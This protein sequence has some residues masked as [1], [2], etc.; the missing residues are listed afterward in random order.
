MFVAI[1]LII[2]GIVLFDA[3]SRL[4]IVEKR[5][6]LLESDDHARTPF[7]N[8]VTAP[9]PVEQAADPEPPVTIRPA[10][11]VETAAIPAALQP[12]AERDAPSF[13]R[14]DIDSVD[15]VQTRG[16]GFE[17][18]FGRRLPIWAGGV[19]L[20]VAGV[21]LVK[22]SIDA[23]L[24]SPLVRVVFG[25]LFGSA[26]IGGADVA[27]RQESRVRDPRV[28]QSLAGAGLATLY[29]SILAAH[30]LYDLIGPM[31][32]FVGLAGVTALAMALSIRFGAPSA[33]LGLVG[34]LAA[35]ALVNAGQPNVP[36]LSCYLALA[37]GG[38]CTLSRTQRWLWLGIG[39]LIGGAGW[40]VAMLVLGALD[41]GASISVALLLIAL[42]VAF[43]L[44]AF[45]GPRANSLRLAAAVIAAAQ[46]AALVATGGF[47]L[48]N[49]G[50][51]GLLSIAL[52]W[53]GSRAPALRPSGA[54]GLG[55]ALF[56]AGAWPIPNGTAFT[57][58]AL[59]MAAIYGGAALWRLW[60]PDGSLIEAGQVA[61]IALGGVAVSLVHFYRDGVSERFALL[62]LV[63]AALP[64]LAMTLGWRSERDEDARF[65]LLATAAAL[66]LTLSGGLAFPAWSLPITVA[67][68]GAGLLFLS[69]RADDR[70]VEW[71]GWAFAGS[72]LVILLASQYGRPESTRLF[73]EVA[74]APAAQALLRWSAIALV[75]ALFAWRARF[76]EG[77]TGA[78]GVAVLLGYGALAQV[79][80]AIWLPLVP[81][82]ALPLLAEGARLRQVRLT[83]ALGTA[84]FVSL[85]WAVW[86]LGAWAV[87]ALTSLLGQP[88]L[89]SHLPS[90][91]DALRRLALPALMLAL[92][93]WRMRVL[94]PSLQVPAV[95]TTAILGGV[96]AHI[97]YKQL[98]HLSDMP[99]VVRFAFVERTLWQALLL[100]AAGAVWHLGKAPRIALGLAV[101]A[102]VHV[103]LYT[104]LLHDPLWY[105]QEV[106]HLPIVNLLIPAFAMPYVALA[107]I[108]RLAPDWADRMRRPADMLRMATIILFAYASLRQ[109]FAG[110]VL[111]V[112]P[113]G[114]AEDIVRSVLA[115]ALAIGFLLWGM[116]R[117]ARD[118]RIA[119]LLLML[120]AV[121]KVFLFDASGL[122]GLL[123]IGSFLAL[124]FSLI[125]IGWL[126][127]RLL[128]DARH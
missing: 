45:S 116:R 108:A 115:L 126:Y 26:L 94:R 110:S 12:P 33:L 18:L 41:A 9:P 124:G 8:Q 63:A 56:L 3:R 122:H 53:L 83:P 23:G 42:G 21:L 112:V 90:V 75:A 120:G 67:A 127:N 6:A 49:W 15:A 68:V 11:P 1:V 54:V 117:G 47:T 104:L 80:P 102:L 106:G 82:L 93:L 121:A 113:L 98:F 57:L 16:I 97:V 87:P 55:I 48:L 34:G 22:Y 30:G 118:W 19:T 66:L 52:V 78:Q 64:A 44:L 61:A 65:A 31:T 20:A 43:P 7:S 84:L 92:A 70:R 36:L 39:A 24:L 71:S 85:G 99:D 58:V 29:A 72:A 59:G 50:L 14:P 79:V 2:L 105:G 77:R 28:R 46:V 4:Q 32:A 62:A 37:V 123:R 17:E 128:S 27:L 35:P 119:S 125:G 96:A 114:E 81:A 25:L 74:A 5:L 51:F 91:A 73:G 89:A 86:P 101:A 69:L 38:L 13:A 95:A 107:L 103:L 100:V 10:P 60:R 109:L 88:L 111:N 76:V 40:G